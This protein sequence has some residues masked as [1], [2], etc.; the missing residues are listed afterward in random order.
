MKSRLG[1]L[2]IRRGIVRP[3]NETDTKGDVI[4]AAGA[5]GAAAGIAAA[6]A[7]SSGLAKSANATPQS[8]NALRSSEPTNSRSD[9]S[10][11][12]TDISAGSLGAMAGTTG[13]DDEHMPIA[14]SSSDKKADKG[15]GV[16]ACS[17]GGGV[18][19]AGL[20]KAGLA[21]YSKNHLESKHIDASFNEPV[22]EVDPHKYHAEHE[23]VKHELEEAA[24]EGV[25]ANIPGQ[26]SG[27]GIGMESSTIGTQPFTTGVIG[28][29]P[30]DEINRTSKS[31]PETSTDSKKGKYTAGSVAEG[32][33]A[34]LG[35]SQVGK[36][37]HSSGHSTGHPE[38][39]DAAFLL[40]AKE[41][42]PRKYHN[43]HEKAKHELELAAEAGLLANIPGHSA[44][45]EIGGLDSASGEHGSA[46]SGHDNPEFTSVSVLGVKETQK[47]RALAHAAVALLDDRPE[48]LENVLGL[49][50][51]AQTGTVTDEKGQFLSQLGG[52]SQQESVTPHGGIVNPKNAE[53]L[54]GSTTKRKS[55]RSASF[56][57]APRPRKLAN[58]F[59]VPET[60][61]ISKALGTSEIRGGST[62]SGVGTSGISAGPQSTTGGNYGHGNDFAGKTRRKSSDFG[63]DSS[64]K[65]SANLDGADQYTPYLYGLG[66]TR[67]YSYESAEISQEAEPRS[68]GNFASDNAV[69]KQASI[70]APARSAGVVE[71]DDKMPGSFFSEV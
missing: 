58:P 34:V 35:M 62:T 31:V 38:H 37:D 7:T 3:H 17:I 55:A 25:L 47:A 46:R 29:G 66:S 53:I 4:G 14:S 67:N 36:S 16:G 54:S 15:V 65:Q 10:P 27:T 51:D 71:D 2:E 26:H 30:S 20:A 21:H 61:N 39:I 22:K 42:D 33:A 49:K 50:V 40:P 57:D 12:H 52:F 59:D 28:S 64:T 56:G 70:N 19:T 1:R 48:V 11:K 41:V 63:L 68:Q 32:A 8:T 13:Y 9:G 24:D 45:K 43:Q 60:L 18:A 69:P 6:G 5:A 23:K 44:Q